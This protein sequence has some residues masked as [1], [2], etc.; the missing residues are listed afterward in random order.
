MFKNTTIKAKLW[1][2]P[3]IIVVAL[4]GLYIVIKV[5]FNNLDIKEADL[6]RADTIAEMMLDARITEK[7]FMKFHEDKY[8]QKFD[9]TISDILKVTDELKVRFVE[10]EPRE[11]LGKVIRATKAYSDGFHN[12]QKKIKETKEEKSKMESLAQEVEDI[13]KV[14]RKKLESQKEKLIKNGASIEEILEKVEKLDDLIQIERQIKEIRISEKNY[15]AR[16][17][18]KYVDDVKSRITKINEITK[19]LSSEFKSKR[20]KMLLSS[21]SVALDT[22]IGEFNKVV[23]IYEDSQKILESMRKDATK[24]LD[25]VFAM[26][27]DQKNDRDEIQS[28]LSTVIT[29]SFL[30]ISILMII[31]SV[32]IAKNVLSSIDNLSSG[33]DS[34]FKFLNK[35]ATTVDRLDDSSSDEI[36]SMAKVINENITKT[37]KLIDDDNRLIEEANKVTSRVKHGWYSELINSSTSNASLE[38]FKNGVNEMIIA[39]KQHFVNMNKVLE[40]YAK[41]DYREKLVLDGIEKDGVFDM[42][43]QDINQLREV[44]RETLKE[45]KENGILLDDK[46]DRLIEN[47]TVLNTN[48]NES[49]AALEETAA[50]VEELTSNIKNST[51]NVVS[52]AGYA[53]EVTTLANS[54]QDLATQT[55]KAMDEINTEV[56]AINE[57]ISVIDQ[58]A[59]QT[60]IL[61]LN[62]AVEAATAGEAGKGFAVVAQ[63]VR[64]L[65]SRSA[66]AANEIKALVENASEKANSGKVI[67]NDMI[68]GYDKLNQS[69]SKT[70][71]LISDVEL[72]SKE[73]FSAI[74][75]INHAIGDLDNKTQENASVASQTHKIAK[76]VD[77][78]AKTILENSESKKF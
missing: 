35:E 28:T 48:S 19:E 31:I 58:I 45:N 2:I 38:E 7:N 75:Q 37:K 17:D 15:F 64:N 8:I 36:G 30:I 21:I 25:L 52:M 20:N 41:N 76:D 43:V 46:S 26:S 50:A 47:V 33:L 68:D 27:E 16:E 54:G 18:I 6:S 57:A 55:T 42:L 10:G 5:Q 49:A 66:E 78:M 62:A 72:A 4:L 67:S 71:E 70:V 77:T 56:T 23:S 60:N 1:S 13:V 22:Y 63:E 65:A 39:T 34:F 3:I 32:G 29:L 14:A 69:I 74:E 61:S 51:Q 11:H 59:F 73:Q 9:K 53:N 12:Y 40:K 24:A 44:I